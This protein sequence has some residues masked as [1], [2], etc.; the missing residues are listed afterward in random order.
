MNAQQHLYD[1][2]KDFDTAMMVTMGE[3]ET[4]ACA[5]DGHRGA[6]GLMAT[7]TSAPAMLSTKVDEV[8]H[9]PNVTLTFQSGHR[10]AT[11]TGEVKVVRDQA[12]ID[13]LWKDVWKVWFPKGKNDP[14]LTLI[15]FDAHEGEYL[16]QRGTEGHQVR[17]SIDRL[18]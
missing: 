12:L 14:T 17:L 13:R 8:Q 16:G 9:R 1:L 4:L 6:S 2:L 7:P 3:D 11:L 15:A 10:F 18:R 5:S